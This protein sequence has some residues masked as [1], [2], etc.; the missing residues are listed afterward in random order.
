M[1][2][3]ESFEVEGEFVEEL[4]ELVGVESFE[5]EGQFVEEAFERLWVEVL[6]VVLEFVRCEA[7]GQVV[8][9][10][11]E[12]TI[13]VLA[14]VLLE[15]V[16]VE[17]LQELFDLLQVEAAEAAQ[18]VTEVAAEVVREV[19]REVELVEEGLERRRVVEVW[20][21]QVEVAL[22]GCLGV[23][24]GGLGRILAGVGAAQAF[25]RRLAFGTDALD[26]DVDREAL[27]VG[28]TDRDR[29]GEVA[30]GDRGL[31]RV[32]EDRRRVGAGPVLVGLVHSDAGRSCG[33][34]LVSEDDFGAFA[35]VGQARHV[36]HAGGVRPRDP[37]DTDARR[38]GHAGQ[39]ASQN[40]L[41]TDRGRRRHRR[42]LVDVGGPGRGSRNEL[43]EFGSDPDRRLRH[44][45]QRSDRPGEIL[46]PGSSSAT[47]QR[48]GVVV[49]DGRPS[50]GLVAARG[51]DFVRHG[52]GPGGVREAVGR[53]DRRAC[54][55]RD[56]LVGDLSAE[57]G[58]GPALE[59]LDG[60]DG[61][62]QRCCRLL[63]AQV[64]HDPKQDHVALVL[65]Q[66]R[67]QANRPVVRHDLASGVRFRHRLDRFC[68]RHGPDPP[69][70]APVVVDQAPPSDVE[71]EAAKGVL[72]A[73]EPRQAAKRLGE[74]VVD[75]AIG[76]DGPSS[77][78]EGPQ[79]PRDALEQ[80]LERC[81]VSPSSRVEQGIGGR[82]GRWGRQVGVG[83]HVMN[84]VAIGPGD[85]PLAEIF[86][87]CAHVTFSPGSS[88][89]G[90]RART[91]KD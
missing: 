91:A 83:P 43:T 13:A 52:G 65:G 27:T 34:F 84:I 28:G 31:D 49:G 44:A 32:L 38:Q 22:T 2:G 4:V 21:D 76:V 41:A 1:V 81:A 77:G 75:Q 74:S 45:A 17:V 24:G 51:S 59:R 35:A 7:V 19:Q 57:R 64:G 67:D 66:H 86:R 87:R 55:S 69:A 54:A 37:H 61:L 90:L 79:R 33:G 3:V 63:D 58:E 68:D 46:V 10:E 42:Q 80:R 5:V 73:D 36:D 60:G 9:V 11:R 56:R 50:G 29:D 72:A 48:V 23:A 16:E 14:E 8:E 18:L 25:E 47:Q 78:C 39:R 89:L 82:Q 15:P 40:G 6:E 88:A 30:I 53:E 70:G 85:T 20:E 62:A 71:D 12:A 26:V